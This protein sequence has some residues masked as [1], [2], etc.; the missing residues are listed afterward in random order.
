M[1]PAPKVVLPLVVVTI[2]GLVS[3]TSSSGDSSGLQETGRPLTAVGAQLG[4]FEA[5]WPQRSAAEVAERLRQVTNALLGRSDVAATEFADVAAAHDQQKT[6]WSERHQVGTAALH[7]EYYPQF[8][9]L[10]VENDDVNGDMNPSKDVGEAASRATLA[11]TVAALASAGLLQP[12]HFDVGHAEL[13]YTKHMEAAANET[14][15]QKIAQYRYTVRRQINGIDF[16][17]A[18]LRVV[19]HADGR[20][21]SIRLGGAT[22]ASTLKNGVETPTGKGHMITR[23]VSEDALVAR[24][25]SEERNSRGTKHR[26]MY[27]FPPGSSGGLIEPRHVVYFARASGPEAG[28]VLSRAQYLGYSITDPTAPALLLSDPPAPQ[29]PSDPRPPK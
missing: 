21:A 11:K 22:V 2:M 3:C 28:A 12:E 16:A 15:V 23:Q 9:D 18:G 24:H 17:Q 19:V 20:V 29:S 25:A 1:R 5:Q 10:R 7:I 27:V 13:G 6:R 14:P 4:V 26:L 8:D